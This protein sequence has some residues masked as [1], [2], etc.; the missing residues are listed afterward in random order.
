LARENCRR[1]GL[2]DFEKFSG[3]RTHEITRFSLFKKIEVVYYY[4]FMVNQKFYSFPRIGF[5]SIAFTL[6][7]FTANMPAFADS[8]Q[9][10][11]KGMTKAQVQ[12]IYGEPDQITDTSEGETWTYTKGLSKAFIPF[13]SLAHNPIR[14][15][16]VT[17]HNGRVA[18][19]SAQRGD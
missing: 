8:E 7:F 10:I 6:L 12:K 17:F 15:I 3:A 9:R 13:Y 11:S 16:V 1:I 14:I 4:V 5:F 2:D 19:Y 18:S